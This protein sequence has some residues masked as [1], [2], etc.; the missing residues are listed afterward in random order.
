MH[1]II[2]EKTEMCGED[3]GSRNKN[4]AA[5][6]TCQVARQCYNQLRSAVHGRFTQQHIGRKFIVVKTWYCSE[7]VPTSYREPYGERQNDSD[8]RRCAHP[9]AA[10]DSLIFTSSSRRTANTPMHFFSTESTSRNNTSEK[11]N[12]SCTH[13]SP[14]T[15]L[16]LDSSPLGFCRS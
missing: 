15:A 2:S 12:H 5:I 16:S 4:P 14:T 6:N 10:L 9:A 1:K 3:K 13:Q 11:H 7:R 8:C